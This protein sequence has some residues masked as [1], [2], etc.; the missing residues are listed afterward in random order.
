LNQAT[1]LF[2]TPLA[3]LTKISHLP[4]RNSLSVIT[5]RQILALF[6]PQAAEQTDEQLIA[7]GFA[8][9]HEMPAKPDKQERYR[10]QRRNAGLPDEGFVLNGLAQPAR[11]K[12]TGRS[13][14]LVACAVLVVA[15][16]ISAT[17][18]VMNKKD[19]GGNSPS[20]ASVS[21]A[22]SIIPVAKPELELLDNAKD[23]R[24]ASHA[25]GEIQMSLQRSSC[26]EVKRASFKTVLDGHVA[27]VTVAVVTLPEKKIAT[28]LKQLADDPNG[29]GIVDLAADNHLWPERSIFENAARGDALTD[30]QVRLV[31]A[32]WPDRPSTVDD[33]ALNTLVRSGLTAPL[34]E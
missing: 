5:V 26:L 9:H 4:E 12:K 33:P 20:Q 7:E 6:A 34:P 14:A 31:R 13:I 10:S 11:K 25:F 17:I 24:C 18:V 8:A 21:T 27:A 2:P 15:A 30:N 28:E 32:A 29:G 23:Q 1:V 16:G 3:L 19:T 22:P